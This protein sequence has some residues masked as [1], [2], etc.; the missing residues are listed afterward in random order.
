MAY[1]IPT[2]P[3]VPVNYSC[4]SVKFVPRMPAPRNDS[5][6][7]VPASSRNRK[8]KKQIFREGQ[9]AAGTECFFRLEEAPQNSLDVLYISCGFVAWKGGVNTGFL[10]KVLS[11]YPSPQ[12]GLAKGQGPQRRTPCEMLNC[13]RSSVLLLDS[14]TPAKANLPKVPLGWRH[15]PWTQIKSVGSHWRPS[16]LWPYP[17]YPLYS[18]LLKRY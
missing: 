1:P 14:T 9:T 17:S 8:K 3:Y 10:K 4:F 6:R 11:E 16:K 13:P 7:R 5:T 15:H 18:F 12:A 2:V